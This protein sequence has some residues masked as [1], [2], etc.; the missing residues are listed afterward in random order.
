MNNEINNSRL[1]QL[2]ALLSDHP[3]EVF[4]HYAIASEYKKAQNWEEALSWFEKTVQL[5]PSYIAAYYQMAEAFE[6]N[7]Q[8]A[9]AKK[10][11]ETGLLHAQAA[12]DL[13]SIS[14]FKN[15]LMNLDIED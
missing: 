8:R 10:A 13:K 9:S 7:D 6:A 5:E 14:E 12:K 1:T 2:F 3:E 15:A 11:L 4:L